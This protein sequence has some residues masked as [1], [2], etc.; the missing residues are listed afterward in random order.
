MI[1][2]KKEKPAVTLDSA[3]SSLSLSYIIAGQPPVLTILHMHCMSHTEYLSNT[4]DIHQLWAM[5]TLLG[6][7]WKILSGENPYW[8]GTTH[9]SK[10]Y[11]DKIPRVTAGLNGNINIF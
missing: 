6:V 9:I 10:K 11:A 8:K 3:A 5:R 1:W 2:G 7:D 4:P